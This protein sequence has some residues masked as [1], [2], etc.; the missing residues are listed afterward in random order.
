MR[1]VMIKGMIPA[2]DYFT[3]CI[4]Q[5]LKDAGI[6]YYIIDTNELEKTA[7]DEL[8]RFVSAEDACF[9]TFNNIGTLLTEGND[10][11]WEKYQ[12]PVYSF[13]Q[14]HPRNFGDMLNQPIKNY[15]AICLDRKHA[16]FIKRYYPKV[17][18]VYFMPNGGMETIPP[19]P[20]SERTIDILYCGDCQ[21]KVKAF[22]KLEFFEDGGKEFYEKC[23]LLMQNDYSLTTEEAI[24]KCMRS[25]FPGIT[26]DSLRQ[27]NEVIAIY[28]EF[29]ARRFFK[30]KVMQALDTAGVNVEIYGNN[31]EDEEYNYGNNIH[32]HSRI[33]P[34]EC[35]DLMGN[36]KITLNFLPWHKDG[37]SER[38]Y[39]SMLNGSVCLVDESPFLSETFVNRKDLL[40]FDMGQPEQMVNRLKELLL[41]QDLSTLACIAANGYEK[42]KEK[43]TWLNR[44]EEIVRIMNTR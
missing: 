25:Y 26:D 29:V 31:W 35:N 18:N 7:G 33:S 16:D 44:A 37:C 6:P 1:I 19:H 11:F 14:D 38:T 10:N 5:G 27:I 13:I 22:P 41:E 43:E 40:F 34:K 39:N 21:E 15:S 2:L 17:E 23:T 42:C 12:V 8:N 20:Y 24:E 4:A 30:Q 3:D 9:F 28:I 36:A 32:I